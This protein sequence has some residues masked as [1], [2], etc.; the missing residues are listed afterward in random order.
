M[1][2]MKHVSVSCIL[3]GLGLFPLSN[4]LTSHRKA[5]WRFLIF[6]ISAI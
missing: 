1:L 2:S 3:Q 4:W 5:Q 6:S